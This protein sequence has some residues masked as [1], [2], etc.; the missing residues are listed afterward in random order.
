MRRRREGATTERPGGGGCQITV[1]VERGVRVVGWGSGEPPIIHIMW[2]GPPT[3]SPPPLY[4]WAT[5]AGA[6][7][8]IGL[9]R[10]FITLA[11]YKVY[12]LLEFLM[13]HNMFSVAMV[14]CIPFLLSASKV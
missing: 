2:M 4:F 10:D 9:A 3:H 7:R 5:V 12:I 13:T 14:T 8:A 11:R 1:W 6:P